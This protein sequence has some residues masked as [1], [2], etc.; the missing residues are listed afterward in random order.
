MARRWLT[1]LLLV[2]VTLPLTAQRGGWRGGMS[3]FRST[4][5]PYDGHFTFARL[6]YPYHG[7]WAFDWPEMEDNLSLI[8]SEITTIPLD[9]RGGTIVRMDDPELMKFPLAYLSE[10][11]YWHPSDSEVEGLRTYLL[12][13]GFLIVDDF[14]FEPEWAVFESAMR[15]VLPQARID[16]LTVDHPVF[17]TF[18][19]IKTLDVPYPGG[20]GERGLMGE[21]F[22]IYEDNDPKKRLM[23]VINYNMDVGDYIEH[24]G[25]SWYAEGPTHEAY[26]FGINYLIYGMTR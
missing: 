22:G 16:R 19:E 3:Q 21:F 1:L 6:W 14:H 11:G 2:T 7:G 23:V 4:S 26:K 18:F 10:P 12:K 13:G 5:L 24:S 20:L 8:V 17:N 15:R 25:R 9:P